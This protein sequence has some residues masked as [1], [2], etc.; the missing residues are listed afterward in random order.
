MLSTVKK[1]LALSCECNEPLWI[2]DGGCNVGDFSQLALSEFPGCRILAFEPDPESSAKAVANVVAPGQFELV[3][4]GLGKARGRAE[5]FRGSN[6]QTHSLLPRPDSGLRPYYPEAASLAGGSYV[7][8]VSLDDECEARGIEK[9][10]LVKLDLQGGE[11]SALA[12]AARLLASGAI[13]VLIVEAAFVTKYKDQP[14]LWEIWG[15]MHSTG[16]S[17]YS[18]EDVKVGLYRAAEPSLRDG[19]WNQCDAIFLSK[20][21][22][23]SLDAQK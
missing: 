9:L 4:A 11:L 22:R 14:L 3:E 7:D 17:L 10:D 18:L 19:Q 5:F 12:G 6:S 23:E 20:E 15:Y 21:I 16:Y 8:V 2:I 1:L 13:R